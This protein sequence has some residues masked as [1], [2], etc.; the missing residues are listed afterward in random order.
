MIRYFGTNNQSAPGENKNEQQT[1]Y[2][3]RSSNDTYPVIA[4][5][6]GQANKPDCKPSF[7]GP[8]L[9]S[10]CSRSLAH[11]TPCVAFGSQPRRADPSGAARS[12]GASMEAVSPGFDALSCCL[13]FR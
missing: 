8:P 9:K 5:S 4:P 6:L 11:L 7:S 10:L 12:A 13:A 3:Q 1:V 2:Q